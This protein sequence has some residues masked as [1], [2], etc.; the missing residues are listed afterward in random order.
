MI[1]ILGSLDDFLVAH[2]NIVSLDDFNTDN[3]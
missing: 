2:D 1:K 3:Q